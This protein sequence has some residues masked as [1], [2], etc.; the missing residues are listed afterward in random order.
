M[1][2][3]GLPD[4][5]VY[6]SMPDNRYDAMRWCA[7]A[8]GTYSDECQTVM[9]KCSRCNCYTCF[10]SCVV[11]CPACGILVEQLYRSKATTEE[12]CRCGASLRI[13]HTISRS[14]VTGMSCA[15]IYLDQHQEDII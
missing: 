15:S 2:V 14:V 3:L 1:N 12:R 4:E 9:V 6:N 7:M 8:D 13:C 5:L 10:T 11:R